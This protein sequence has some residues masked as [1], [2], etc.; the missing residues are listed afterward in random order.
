LGGRVCATANRV[1]RQVD[2]GRDMWSGARLER[3]A[4]KRWRRS[5]VDGYAKM[6]GP[7]VGDTGEAE[8][9]RVSLSLT[10]FIVL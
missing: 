4:G 3:G 8:P 1:G 5:G 2:G 9:E 10:F 6:S 7:S